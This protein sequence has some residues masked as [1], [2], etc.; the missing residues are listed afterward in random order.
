MIS[1]IIKLSVRLISRNFPLPWPWLFWVSQELHL[2]V[3]RYCLHISQKSWTQNKAIYSAVFSSWAW[4]ISDN[5][6]K[7]VFYVDRTTITELVMQGGHA[8]CNG[9]VA[10]AMLGCKVGYSELPRDWIAG[11]LPK[12][13]TWLNAKLNSLL[14]MMALPW[15]R[16]ALNYLADHIKENAFLEGFSERYYATLTHSNNWYNKQ[17]K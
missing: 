4:V 14:D 16:K 13:V 6:T 11:L 1:R 5:I 12:Q 17:L 10:G 9:T 3:I 7:S 8:T 15:Q 2:R